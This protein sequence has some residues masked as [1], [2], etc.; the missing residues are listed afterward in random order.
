MYFYIASIFYIIAVVLR[1]YYNTQNNSEGADGGGD[2]ETKPE[3]F[4]L[5][6]SIVIL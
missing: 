3:I 5:I 4:L 1:G 6:Q 2:N